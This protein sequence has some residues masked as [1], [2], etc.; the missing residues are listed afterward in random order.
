MHPAN[1]TRI[2]LENA[3]VK[4]VFLEREVKIDFYCPLA[5]TEPAQLSLLLIND[6]QNM[7]ELGLSYLLEQM[8]AEQQLAPLLCVAIHTGEERKLEYGIAGTTDYK[9]RGARA[10][11]YSSFILDELLPF[12]RKKYA[13]ISFTKNGFAG[14]SLGG[15]SALDI[16]W[17]HPGEFSKAGIFSGSLWWRTL[18]QEDKSYDDEKHRLMHQQV[19]SGNY[20]PRLQFFFQCGNMDETKDRNK[21][22]IIDSI[23]DTLDLI[24]ELVNKGYD[25]ETDIRYV[26]VKDGRH[27]IAT[28][29][30][31]MPDFLKWGWG[32]EKGR[33]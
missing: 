31:V 8:A 32:N 5:L 20:K 11:L 2:Q 18:D 1:L 22:G 12:I 13:G 7:A 29:G 21:N 23:D 3:A 14:F 28:W 4:S 33:K 19:R 6:G 17:N 10:G 30:R 25:R 9:G 15:L 26:E 27:D 16:A 24:Q